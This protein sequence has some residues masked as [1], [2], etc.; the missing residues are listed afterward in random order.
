MSLSVVLSFFV[1]CGFLFGYNL[2]KTNYIHA[3]TLE[4]C[5]LN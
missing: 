4:S 2:K 5:S 1:V 3:V